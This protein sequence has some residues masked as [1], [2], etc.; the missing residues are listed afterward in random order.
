MDGVIFLNKR[1]LPNNEL[2][3]D[4]DCV[5]LFNLLHFKAKS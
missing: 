5:L 3:Q 1:G 2:E 4:E